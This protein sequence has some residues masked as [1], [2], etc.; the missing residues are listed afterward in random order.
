MLQRKSIFEY[1]HVEPFN[2]ARVCTEHADDLFCTALVPA[3]QQLRRPVIRRDMRSQTDLVCTHGL[4][5]YRE[6]SK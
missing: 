3:H 2:F 6:Y 4:N 5:M 1:G